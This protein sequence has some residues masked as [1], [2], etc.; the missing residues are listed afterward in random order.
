[1]AD[2][3]KPI[4]GRIGASEYLGSCTYDGTDY[5]FCI[6]STIMGTLN[7]TWHYYGPA[8]NS[9]GAD[10]GFP[11][12]SLRAGWA[13]DVFETRRGMVYAQD[14]WMWNSSIFDPDLFNPNATAAVPVVSFSVI[15]GG[16]GKYEEASGWIG[17]ILDDAGQW[18]GYM[19]GELCTPDDD[20][21]SDD[22]SDD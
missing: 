14:N 18:K 17:A 4:N 2:R 15:T 16:T 13:L 1:M 11:Y 6:D 20:G 5:A 19:K 21:D 12:S 22:D 10:P 9:I 3:C 7:G 8:G